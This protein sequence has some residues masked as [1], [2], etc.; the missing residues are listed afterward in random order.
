MLS[1]NVSDASRAT[2]LQQSDSPEFSSPVT[3][4]VS[5]EGSLTITGLADGEYYFRLMQ[6]DTPL[7]EP[8]RVMVQHHDLERAGL[9]FVLGLILFIVLVISILLGARNESQ[10]HG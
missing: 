5:P 2:S 7:T 4:V 6:A 1:W 9:F 8:L 3:R 10:H